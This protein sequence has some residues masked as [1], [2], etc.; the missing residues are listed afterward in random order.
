M[1]SNLQALIKRI[2]KDPTNLDLMNKVA[3][4]YYQS[5]YLSKYCAF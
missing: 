1:S 4:V 5:R 2:E 3:M